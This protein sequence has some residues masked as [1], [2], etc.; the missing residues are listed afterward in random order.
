M[1][2]AQKVQLRE[3]FHEQEGR[4]DCLVRIA[5]KLPGG[6]GKSQIRTHLRKLGLQPTKKKGASGQ[7]G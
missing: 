4:R 1:C 2:H 3:L 5:N 7:V 6:F